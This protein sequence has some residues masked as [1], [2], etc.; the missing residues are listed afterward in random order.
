MTQSEIDWPVSR[1]SINTCRRQHTLVRPCPHASRGHLRCR[2]RHL[3]GDCDWKEESPLEED[4]HIAELM[5]PHADVVL[6]VCPPELAQ[7]ARNRKRWEESHICMQK[8]RVLGGAGEGNCRLG[9]VNVCS[10]PFMGRLLTPPQWSHSTQPPQGEG[11]SS[12]RK[13][14]AGQQLPG[15]SPIAPRRL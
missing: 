5:V 2:K 12:S 14:C 6:A 10:S 7:P 13:S 4:C 11:P 1:A 3:L 8:R 15:S 9:R